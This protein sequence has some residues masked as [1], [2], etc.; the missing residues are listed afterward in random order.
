MKKAI[1]VLIF[2][3]FALSQYTIGLEHKYEVLEK[4]KL[5]FL[6]AIYDVYLSGCQGGENHAMLNIL[7]H[8]PPGDND[9]EHCRNNASSAL[10]NFKK[11]YYDWK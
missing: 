7:T 3:L 9:A 10:Q 11:A 6:D 8:M 4:Q 5:L 2:L 1:S